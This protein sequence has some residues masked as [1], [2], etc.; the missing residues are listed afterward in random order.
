MQHSTNSDN[1]PRRIALVDCNNF[2]ASCER[3]FNPRWQNRPV[4]VL[5]NNDGCIIARS[6]ELKEAG[7]KMGAPYFQYRDQ[8]EKMGAVVVSSNYTLY[9]DMSARVMDVLSNYTPEFEIYSIDEAWLDLT[10]FNPAELDAYGREIVAMTKKCTGIP[11]SM[12]IGSTKTLAKIANR[13]CKKRKVPG[14]VFNLGSAG[15]I[16]SVLQT[17]DVE[18]IWGIGRRW[19]EKLRQHGI[20]TALDLKRSDP[21]QMRKRYSVVMQRLILELNGTP[22]LGMDALEPK[23]EIIASRSFG[24]RVTDKN[25]LIEAVSLHATR[26]AEKLRM[27]NSATGCMAVSIRTGKHNPNDQ[28]FGKSVTIS[29]P[30]A[31]SDTR[32]LIGAA[33]KGIERIY[34][35]GPR[36][37]KAG[38]ILMD[39]VQQSEVQNN[40][41]SDADSSQSSQ[42]MNTIDQL[43]RLYGKHTMRFAAEGMNK[44]WAMKRDRMTQAFTTNWKEL[45]IAFAK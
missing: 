15:S 20:V 16:D 23:K 42:L 25:S 21:T 8:L 30:T 10:G 13:I 26:A 34:Q 19:A 33:R 7:I 44:K 18:D 39:I 11:V 3:V 22:C 37:A 27:Q 31:T 24:E 40:L 43:N 5:S 1:H 32:V 14:A 2:Y 12:G 28:Y 17:L 35:N 9:G 38:I 6:D 4:G 29:F 41:F 36:Y 45:P